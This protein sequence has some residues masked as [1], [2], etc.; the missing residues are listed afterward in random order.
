MKLLYVFACTS[1]MI[2]QQ[3]IHSQ[4]QVVNIDASYFNAAGNFTN[5]SSLAT[6][7]ELAYTQKALKNPDFSSPVCCCARSQF[8]DMK[9]DGGANTMQLF[10]FTSSCSSRRK[11]IIKEA[12]SDEFTA[13]DKLMKNATV[14]QYAWNPVSDYTIPK[15]YPILLLPTASLRYDF[16]GKQHTLLIMPKAEGKELYLYF[17]EFYKAVMNG[18]SD[19]DIK[20]VLSKTAKA[21]DRLGQTV[22]YVE[23]RSGI[24]HFDLHARNV[25]FDEASENVYWIDLPTV[26]DGKRNAYGYDLA[27]CLFGSVYHTVALHG[28]WKLLSIKDQDLWLKTTI[29]NALEGYVNAMIKLDA[30]YAQQAFANIKHTVQQFRTFFKDNLTYDGHKALIDSI[31]ANIEKNI[32]NVSSYK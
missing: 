19:Q 7:I 23:Y 24:V 17:D 31:F 10:S 22:A 29:S 28:E 8:N 30:K 25:F 13:L 32:T 20:D 5:E 12:K 26:A 11:Y 2:S 18:R 27:Y 4:Q 21:Y 15:L 3:P 9:T 1:M 16:L 14:Q 6:F